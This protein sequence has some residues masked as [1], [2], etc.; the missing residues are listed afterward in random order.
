[1]SELESIFPA[2][3][4][5]DRAIDDV[6]KAP[7][8]AIS[9]RLVS[10]AKGIDGLRSLKALKSLWCF[11]IDARSLAAICD[12]PSLESLYI[13]G[14]NTG[15]LRPLKR[16]V[17]LKILNL[18]GCSKVSSFDAIAE[19]DT[20]EGLAITHF[21]NVRDLSPLSRLT[22][23]RALAV[24]GSI[25]TTMRVETLRP[26]AALHQ[27]EFLH[28]TN[29]KPDDGSLE[30]LANLTRLRALDLANFYSTS[31]MGSL[32]RR[33][34]AT[35]CSWF[36]PYVELASLRCEKCGGAKVMLTG[37]GAPT[38]CPQCDQSRMEKHM[39][40]WAATG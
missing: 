17:A 37:K 23:L 22:R 9:V 8:D 5:W 30:P 26:L 28:L 19:L 14:V 3:R 21:K 35:E 25:W 6:A 34:P 4:Q 2:R 12:C 31:E 24:A 15:D 36:K 1:M 39:R 16:L 18:E 32:A 20:L 33:L 11:K 7:E 27:L 13:D 10:K 38:V 40:E 29:I